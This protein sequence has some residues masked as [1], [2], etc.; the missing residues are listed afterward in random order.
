MWSL[1]LDLELAYST[2]F[3]RRQI[4]INS[5]S[6]AKAPAM[7]RIAETSISVCSLSCVGFQ[8]CSVRLAPRRRATHNASPSLRVAVPTKRCC[9]QNGGLSYCN[10]LTTERVPPVPRRRRP[11]WADGA[12]GAERGERER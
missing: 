11:E 10:I 8:R 2:A 3:L 7:M 1:G 6:T 12:C 5:M 9:E 4:M